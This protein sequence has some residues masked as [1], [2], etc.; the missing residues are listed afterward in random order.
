MSRPGRRIVAGETLWDPVNP[1]HPENRAE[2]A[3]NKKTA[4]ARN[5]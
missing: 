2:A 1:P 3:K 4:I 5:R